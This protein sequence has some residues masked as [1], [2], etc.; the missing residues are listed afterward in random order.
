MSR[1]VNWS[2]SLWNSRND[3]QRIA[4]IVL[5]QEFSQQQRIPPYTKHGVI[6][7]QPFDGHG[8]PRTCCHGGRPSPA[9]TAS[10]QFIGPP[11]AGF[12]SPAPTLAHARERYHTCELSV[13]QIHGVQLEH[14]FFSAPEHNR[15]ACTICNCRHYR[16]TAPGSLWYPASKGHNVTVAGANDEGEGFEEGFVIEDDI[17][18]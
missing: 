3:V 8:P 18:T 4:L 9:K 6:S 13:P 10:V 5:A 14:M 12:S 2:G 11:R 7:V 17:R 16:E 15:K 1:T